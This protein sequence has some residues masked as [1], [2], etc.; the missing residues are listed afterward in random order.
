M[1]SDM[2]DE[3]TFDWVA[4]GSVLFFGLLMMMAVSAYPKDLTAVYVVFSGMVWA[5][6]L[7]FFN[8]H[9]DSER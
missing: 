3:K 7:Q 5:L 2:L 1:V 6:I 9:G 4:I 8:P